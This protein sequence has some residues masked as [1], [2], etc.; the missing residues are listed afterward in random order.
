[1]NKKYNKVIKGCI[2]LIITV[3]ILFVGQ[4]VW[5]NYAVDFPLGK[6]LNNISEVEK[7]TWEKG[8]NIGDAVNIYVKL[9][10]TDNLQ[11]TYY[12]INR[13]IKQTLNNKEYIL[14]IEDNSSL[15]LENTYYDIHYYIQKAIVDGDFPLLEEKVREKSA[16]AGV[17]AKLYVDEKNIYLQMTKNDNALYAV[18]AR[19]SDRTG[20]NI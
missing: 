6:K 5:Q 4:G 12:E 8:S 10:N 20:G 16:S 14:E 18:V 3:T 13:T 2:A 19:H 17:S 11:K 9:N 1:M 15:E 7:V